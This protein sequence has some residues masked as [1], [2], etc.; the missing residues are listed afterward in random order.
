MRISSRAHYGALAAVDL[1]LQGPHVPV[2]AKAI[3]R[4]HGIPVR[5]LE[6]VLHALKKAGLIQSHRGAQGGYHLAKSPE[7]I[8]LLDIFEALDGPLLPSPTNGRGSVRTRPAHA[9]LGEV[10]ENIREAEQRVLRGTSL[11]ALTERFQQ[12]HHEQSLMYHI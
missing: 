2:Q 5:F 1:A 12:L 3:A 8:S 7:E 9:L 10:W 6:H 11:R 4:R